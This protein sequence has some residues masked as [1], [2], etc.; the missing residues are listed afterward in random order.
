MPKKIDSK[1][2]S[3]VKSH[4]Q[5]L[6][7]SLKKKHSKELIAHITDTQHQLDDYITQV[8]RK[9]ESL[10]LP[11]ELLNMIVSHSTAAFGVD[12]K[13]LDRAYLILEWV[14]AYTHSGLGDYLLVKPVSH[15]E[16]LDIKNIPLCK[17]AL[18][19]S[20][21]IRTLVATDSP[22]LLAPFLSGLAR[23]VSVGNIKADIPESAEEVMEVAVLALFSSCRNALVEEEEEEE[24]RETR[25]MSKAEAREAEH[26]HALRVGPQSSRFHSRPPSEPITSKYLMPA[27]DKT[28]MDGYS[29]P[30]KYFVQVQILTSVFVSFSHG[31][32]TVGNTAGPLAAIVAAYNGEL[33]QETI[34]V[35]YWIVVLAAAGIVVGLATMGPRVMKTIGSS[36]TKLNPITGF[37]VQ[38]SSVV[39]VLVCSSL[40]MPISTTHILIGAVSGAG[41]AANGWN[42]LNGKVLAGIGIS[43]LITLPI[44]GVTTF[45]LFIILRAIFL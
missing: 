41:V 38:I 31:S 33:D 42:S 12:C 26:A 8:K 15:I 16:I 25:K 30:E 17:A 29:G 14:Q 18:K 24:M 10:P 34:P 35:A 45:L 20:L 9:K 32:N 1:A 23:L 28:V 37:V 7:K 4:L 6:K 3:V 36:I 43:W 13:G 19:F 39:A 44:A 11:S 27:R 21:S 22:E 5:E 40:Q 2:L